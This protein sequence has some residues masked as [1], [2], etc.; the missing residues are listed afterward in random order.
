MRIKAK[1][2]NHDTLRDMMVWCYGLRS[3]DGHKRCIGM[4]VGLRH[5]AESRGRVTQITWVIISQVGNSMCFAGD[6]SSPAGAAT[7]PDA[8]QRGSILLA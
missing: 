4:S 1:A 3:D 2:G 6:C 8:Y 7:I 5:G